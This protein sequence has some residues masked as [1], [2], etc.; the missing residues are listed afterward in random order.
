MS[1]SLSQST[2]TEQ[3][4]RRLE[5][6]LRVF[7]KALPS[8]TWLAILGLILVVGFVYVA[9]MYVRDSRTIGP[10]WASFL[11]L[12]RACVYL[13]LALAFLLPA[14]QTWYENKQR[15]KVVLLFDTSLSMSQVHDD[16]P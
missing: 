12:L 1:E 7:G 3:I 5:E 2:T 16:L 6:P 9:W 10:W 11:G 14:E 4:F 15:S 13:L 8:W